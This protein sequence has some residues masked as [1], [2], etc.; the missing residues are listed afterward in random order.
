MSADWRDGIELRRFTPPAPWPIH[1]TSLYKLVEAYRYG[2][3]LRR[4]IHRDERVHGQRVDCVWIGCLYEHESRMLREM[5]RLADRPWGGLYLQPALLAEAAG[6]PPPSIRTRPV[7][8]VLQDRR[9]AVLAVIDEYAAP[10]VRAAVG[11]VPVAVVPDL[12]DCS[13]EQA[14]PLGE[15]FRHLAGGRPLVLAIGALFPSK[16]TTTLARAAANPQASDLAFAFVGEIRWDVFND[17]DARTLRDMFTLHANTFLHTLRVPDGPAYNAV[18]GACDVLYA[19][20]HDF[21]H[22]SN[23]LTKAALLRKPII[24]SDGYVMGA[25]V[26]KFR[27]GEVVPQDDPVATLAAIRRIT[28]DPAKWRRENN[29]RWDEYLAEHSY[30]ALQSSMR[31]LFATAFGRANVATR[32]GPP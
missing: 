28:D 1:P 29:P 14:H 18:V 17:A 4:A 13:V 6:G 22:S 12:T 32:P 2:L 8:T 5:V 23:T 10:E 30:A 20:Y 19:A 11:T 26:R 3:V 21:A 27:L 16:G 24:V 15:K 31:E 7:V 9:L 25:R